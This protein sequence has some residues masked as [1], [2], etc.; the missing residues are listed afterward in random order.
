M[1]KTLFWCVWL[2]VFKPG[3]VA[4]PVQGSGS[5]FWLG[6]QVAQ[7]NLYFKKNQND[8]VLI[9]KT[10]VNG[11]QLAFWQGHR[12]AQVNPYFKKNQNDVLLIKKTKVNGL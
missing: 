2:I 11:M 1:F 7:V 6:H 3:L 4:G 12:V 9:K 8:V 10:K 5:G